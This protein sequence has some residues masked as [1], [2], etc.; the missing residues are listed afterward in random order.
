MMK[1]YIVLSVIVV[2][3]IMTSC[4]HYRTTTSGQAY[5]AYLVITSEKG[6]YEMPVSVML[7]E[8]SKTL[9]TAEVVAI[10]HTKKAN[11]KKYAVKPGKHSVIV[12]SD[13]QE[14][15]RKTI[16]VTQGQTLSIY[17][18]PKK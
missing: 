1:K 9:F 16:Y 11:V 8:D 7:D 15:Y 14:V 10:E 12:F 13:Q 17:L 6:A 18:S 5:E 2:L 3:G 4:T